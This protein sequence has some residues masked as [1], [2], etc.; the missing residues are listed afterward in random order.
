MR[1]LSSSYP[2]HVGY[3]R[4][5]RFFYF[6]LTLGACDGCGAFCHFLKESPNHGA[7]VPLTKSIKPIR[8]VYIPAKGSMHSHKGGLQGVHGG[9]HK[10]RTIDR[11]G[12]QP[13]G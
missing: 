12:D 6:G 5:I 2:I 4:S 7:I 3:F 13:G 9:S 10:S 8:A 11:L 1:D